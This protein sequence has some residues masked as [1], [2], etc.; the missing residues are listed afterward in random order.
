MTKVKITY[1]VD[2]EDIPSEVSSMLHKTY[3]TLKQ[4]IEKLDQS[5][6]DKNVAGVIEL[7]DNFRQS[8]TNIDLKLDD[9]YS[10]L[11]GY[12]GEVRSN[13]T[14]DVKELSEKLSE[15]ENSLGHMKQKNE[16]D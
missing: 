9:C 13:P 10:I 12:L 7:I 16:S 14:Q 5:V 4:E 11:V 15:L 2:L 1:T 3:W 8:L 6:T